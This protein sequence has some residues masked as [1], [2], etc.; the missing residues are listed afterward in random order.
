MFFFILKLGVKN[1][2]PGA[3]FLPGGRIIETKYVG[4]KNAPHLHA[5]GA[6]KSDLTTLAKFAPGTQPSARKENKI[7]Y[8]IIHAQN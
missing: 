4:Y 8:M 6:L 2:R 3:E 5:F 7:F 1:F